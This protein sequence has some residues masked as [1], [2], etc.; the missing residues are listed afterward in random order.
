MTVPAVVAGLA[1][2]LREFGTK[3]WGEALQ[4]A[5]R[6]AEEGFSF[7]SEHQRY[8][9]RCAP[10]FDPQSLKSL[11]PGD[12]LPR[13]GY[14]WRQPELAKLLRRL[15]NEGPRSFYEGDIPRQIVRYLHD[16][17]G[18]LTE[19]DFE[20]YQPQLV[21][22]VH[23]VCQGFDLHTPPPPSGGIT[24]LGIM[25]TIE[26]FG[27]NDFEPWSGPYFHVLAE[28]TKI[29]WNERHGTLGDPDFVTAPIDELTSQT[30]AEAHAK[31]SAQESRFAHERRQTVRRI[32]PT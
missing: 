26:R 7:D 25:K 8:L 16:R 29:C 28:A 14:H 9:D 24:S 5:I 21:E 32:P 19:E 17:G 11:F 1:L 10:K 27:V 12:V 4:T 6:L 30:A 15:A 20:S 31:K 23:T 2:V 18:F 13:T 22:T 3:T